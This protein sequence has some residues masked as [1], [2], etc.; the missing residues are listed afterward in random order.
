MC[1]EN[2]E[3]VEKYARKCWCLK[4]AVNSCAHVNRK[5]LL[6]WARRLWKRKRC[7]KKNT[8]YWKVRYALHKNCAAARAAGCKCAFCHFLIFSANE[9]ELCDI[10]GVLPFCCTATATHLLFKNIET[11]CG[12]Q[13]EIRSL[14]Y[15]SRN[16]SCWLAIS[17]PG[18]VLRRSPTLLLPPAV[19]GLDLLHLRVINLLLL[20]L[21]T[22]FVG[23]QCVSADK[24]QKCSFL[25]QNFRN[26]SRNMFKTSAL[27]YS[28]NSLR[29][30]NE[31]HGH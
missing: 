26:N 14:S 27:T 25:K 8:A 19:R 5:F 21:A 28:L 2:S 29:H 30:C 31:H 16:T 12:K 1:N 4:N 22:L 6:P 11:I 18:V 13:W 15:F 20:V 10:C 24:T 7:I 17:V 9:I 23:T 3:K